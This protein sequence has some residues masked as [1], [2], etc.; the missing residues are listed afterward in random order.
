MWITAVQEIEVGGSRVAPGQVVGVRDPVGARLVDAG[1]AV[2]T[3]APKRAGTAEPAVPASPTASGPTL[4]PN[5]PRAQGLRLA[6]QNILARDD[7]ALLTEDGKPL[8]SAL[9]AELGEDVSAWER[10]AAFAQ[11]EG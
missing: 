1:V 6:S 5:S 10:D 2:E 9:E 4:D 7:A 8:V 11:L 3:E